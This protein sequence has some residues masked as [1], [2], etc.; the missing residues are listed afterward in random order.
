MVRRIKYRVSIFITSK[1]FLLALWSPSLPSPLPSDTCSRCRVLCC[2]RDVDVC[3]WDHA[4]HI[5]YLDSFSLRNGFAHLCRC[6]H[7]QLF[8]L[9]AS[10][11]ALC[12][13]ATLCLLIHPVMDTWVL[14]HFG[15]LQIHLL[16]IFM[17]KTL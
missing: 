11:V 3:T 6:V 12:A 5:L 16:W 2:L 17:H 1:S 14:F 10:T 8:F 9:I 13:Y 7:Q 4:A 15:V